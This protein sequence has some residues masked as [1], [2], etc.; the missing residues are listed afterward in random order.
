MTFDKN[1]VA[2]VDEID[3]LLAIDCGGERHRVAIGVDG[4]LR[5]Y[6]HPA[7]EIAVLNDLYAKAG[8]R[9]P[10]ACAKLLQR[11]QNESHRLPEPFRS[12]KS[13]QSS[14]GQKRRAKAVVRDSLANETPKDRFRRRTRDAVEAALAAAVKDGVYRVSPHE[15]TW[16]VEPINGGAPKVDNRSERVWD[17]MDW[18]RDS[19]GRRRG[20][21]KTHSQCWVY[22]PIR[23]LARVHAQGLAQINGMLC[24]DVLSK[25]PDGRVNVLMLKQARGFKLATSGAVYCP[26]SGRLEWL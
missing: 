23:W 5:F 6:D 24:L 8:K 9:A 19:W 20:K 17:S 21:S 13:E 15:H 10:H 22:V 25:R 12:I 2:V 26:E 11:W 16:Y 14:R 4:K 3:A 18:E 7:A 1:R